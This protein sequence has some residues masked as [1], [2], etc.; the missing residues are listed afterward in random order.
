MAIWYNLWAFGI[1]YGGHL[2]H[3]YQFGMLGPRKI[4]Q[5]CSSSRLGIRLEKQSMKRQLQKRDS[6]VSRN[7]SHTTFPYGIKSTYKAHPGVD[8][9][10]TTFSDFCQFSAEKMFF[11]SQKPI[12]MIK[13]CKKSSSILN[14]TPNFSQFFS[15]RNI[16]IIL[17]AAETIVIF[18]IAVFQMFSILFNKVGTENGRW[19]FK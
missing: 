14:K 19:K 9:T 3:F 16:F 12:C 7:A 5:P 18:L 4:W 10:I 11:F 13:V 15:A 1:I 6:T 2:L 17:T 8:V